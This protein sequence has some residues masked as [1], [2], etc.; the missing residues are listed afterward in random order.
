MAVSGTGTSTSGSL[1]S[2][3]IKWT[4]L[5]SGTDFASVVES[6]VA[7]EQRVITRQETWKADWQ[8]KLESI[9]TLNTRLDALKQG[10]RSYD[11]RSKLLSRKATSSDEK[12]V[13]I[14]NTST[15]AT[16][17]YSVEVA[18]KVQEKIASKTFKENSAI[19]ISHKVDKNGH[20]VGIDGRYIV[21]N[22]SSA[23][24]GEDAD[25]NPIDVNGDI[26][27]S[28]DPN[29]FYYPPLTI[30]MGGKTLSLEY[31][32]DG[33]GD[34][35]ENTTMEELADIISAKITAPG[36]DGPNIRVDAM[37]DKNRSEN[38]TS[39]K[40]NR[41]V[42]TG[43]DA[44]K[45]NHITV[46]D[47]TDMCLDRT[48]IDAP[49]TNSLVGSNIK[50]YVTEDSTY[51]GLV[52]KTFTFVCTN[53]NGNGI[54]GTDDMEFSWADTEGKKGKFVIKAADWDH[55]NNC[56]KED[57]EIAQGLKI[58]IGGA[59]IGNTRMQKNEAFTIDCQAPVLQKAADSGLAQTDKW[60]HKGF[61]DLTSPVTKGNDGKFV[62]S[63]A[64]KEYSIK[65]KDGLGL[66]GLAEAI[67]SSQ[68]NPGVVASVLNDGM[69]TATSYKL[70]LTG[71]H[72]GAENG[73]SI[74][75]KT[76]LTVLD[77]SPDKFEHAREASNSMCRIDGYP[78]DGES[79]IQRSANTVGDVLDGIVLTLEGVG[80][81]SIVIQNDV[82][83]MKTK[84][85]QIVE[86]VNYAKTYIKEQT[87]WGEGKF[88]SEWDEK[89]QQFIRKTTGGK[90]DTGIMIGNYGFQISQS[91][92]D[93]LMTKP[94][95]S[96]E[97]YI[98]ALDP[99]K[100][101]QYTYPKRKVDETVEGQSQERLY[102][103]F[104][105]RNGLIYTRLSDIGIVSDPKQQGQYVIEESKL[106]EALS[107]NPEAVIKLFTFTPPD[108]EKLSKYTPLADENARPRI[109]GFNVMMG[110]AMSDLTRSN[111]VIDSKTG[112]VLKPAK[113]ITTVLAENYQNIIKGIGDKITRETVRIKM[114]RSRL[115]AK[116]SRLET[117]LSNL[118]NQSTKIAAQIE[119]LS[120]NNSK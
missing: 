96:M 89:T 12:V 80:T 66:S 45:A 29:D 63:Y 91:T 86:A 11:E 32:A 6:L 62:F 98:L 99:E 28:S 82:T 42:I 92:I 49:V 68:D 54:L 61:A 33:T 78:N 90:S 51:T 50:P 95:I 26:I 109:G 18:D 119:Q 22:S 111:D 116:F 59:T 104:L 100:E 43:L 64:G 101:N 4:G 75:D 37:F 65:I 76:N 1:I 117:L 21:D 113:G 25:G 110:Y 71:A 40:Y 70:V 84:I 73:I 88:T 83:D 60:V 53:L 55:T 69:G 52:N 15:A 5:A 48:S 38:A 57:I 79:W 102:E 24:I 81:S 85:K 87:A 27:F 2:G 23:K 20:P 17:V 47:P 56:L 9:Q 108:D 105:E 7:I 72:S 93:G 3:A 118:N 114:V 35:T 31:K 39:V 97:E 77:C 30:S 115:E 10:A 36:Y 41:L 106:T 19:G 107:K 120:S 94:I 8:A 13:S 34:F 14:T 103:E 16:G 58:N 67:N 112:D 74:S 46:S 44:G